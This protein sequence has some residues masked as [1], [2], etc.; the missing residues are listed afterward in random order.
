VLKFDKATGTLGGYVNDIMDCD[1][2]GT[3][4]VELDPGDYYLLVEMDWKC[5]FSRKVVVNFYGQ[6]PVALTEDTAPLDIPSLF[7][8]IVLLHEKYT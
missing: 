1:R 5:N 4:R 7:N 3:L 8:E 2:D 6:H